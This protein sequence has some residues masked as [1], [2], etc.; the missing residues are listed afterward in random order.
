MI[1]RIMVMALSLVLIAVLAACGSDPTPTPT[2]TLTTTPTP[3]PAPTPTPE[4]PTPAPAAQ[5]AGTMEDFVITPA[6]TGKDLIDALSEEE[7]SCI[8]SAFGD[9]IFQIMLGTPLLM[10]GANPSAAAPLFC[11]LTTDNVVLI[12]VAFLDAQAGGW[13]EETRKCITDIGLGHPDAVYIG[14]GL[15][16]GPDPI[17]A[18]ETLAYNV[19]IY[20]CLTN[21]EK[22]AFTV[23]LWKGLD[24]QAAATGS[25]IIAL[26]SESE[27]ACVRDGL[28]EEQYLTIVGAQPLE[29]VAIG[30]TVSH[31]IDPETNIKI[32]ANGI[33]WA[34]GGVTEETLSCLEDFARENPAFVVLLS[35]GL[36]GIEAMPVDEFVEVSNAGS[37]QYACMTEEELLRVQE[38]ATAAMQ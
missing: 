7:T 29:A 38:A 11:C 27:A 24:R 31:C 23:S 2:P 20:E 18:A 16:L 28:S 12:G 37:Q 13:T 9:A 14:L 35:S 30:S 17:D 15:A 3:T 6:T 22:K 32:F 33:Q 10:A 36:Q 25:D 26:L 21:E 1:T 34:I 8:R 4:Q 5:V 19:E